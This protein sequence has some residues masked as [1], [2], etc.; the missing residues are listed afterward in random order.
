MAVKRI[1]RL[2]S[3]FSQGTV[4]SAA[5]LGP[6]TRTLPVHPFRHDRALGRR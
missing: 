1:R 2:G 6:I 4:Q 5:C 3:S